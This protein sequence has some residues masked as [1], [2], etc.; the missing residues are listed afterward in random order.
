MARVRESVGRANS[1]AR[2]TLAPL[3]LVAVGSLEVHYQLASSSSPSIIEPGGSGQTYLYGTD[4]NG[5]APNYDSSNGLY[6]EPYGP[7]SV[8]GFYSGEDGVYQQLSSCGATNY[9]NQGDANAAQSD[10]NSVMAMGA[11]QYFFLAGP[12]IN[13]ASNNSSSTA[14]QNWG[15]SQANYALNHFLRPDTNGIVWA[16]IE[17]GENNGAY[18]NGWN[19]EGNSCG[20][21]TG[22][23]AISGANARATFNGFYDTIANA[24]FTPGAYSTSNYWSF[25]FGGYG[26]IPN[27][28]EWTA[29]PSVATNNGG[30]STTPSLG[31]WCDGQGCAAFFGGQS[32]G[33][34][35]AVAWQFAQGT[36]DFDE[37]VWSAPVTQ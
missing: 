7:S 1:I 31:S 26:G 23:A 8:Y 19:S 29:Q 22:G 21:Y 17:G 28:L 33:D 24:G 12:G 18:S 13:A 5:P 4:T 10:S 36:D 25:T 20:G 27:T 34:Q 9:W 3:V 11:S 15:A 32:Y 30:P 35:H 37:S 16:D 14:A 2:L 6:Y